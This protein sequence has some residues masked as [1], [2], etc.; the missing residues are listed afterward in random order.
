MLE[1][2]EIMRGLWKGGFFEHHGEFYDIPSIQIAPMPSAPIPIW[3]GGTSEIALRRAAHH[4]DGWTSEIQTG[5]Q[6][7][8]FIERLDAL[9]SEAGRADLP[10]GS[11]VATRDVYTLEG[12]RA[13]A[14]AGVSYFIS[15]PWAL[16]GRLDAD[17]DTKRDAI[18]RF[19]DEVI[20]AL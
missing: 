18:K 15:V 3:G 11:C 10:F 8:D 13:L 19:A 16:Y 20:G 9:R 4:F 2:I 6:V 5:A 17:L 1:S 7:M 12:Y 14:A